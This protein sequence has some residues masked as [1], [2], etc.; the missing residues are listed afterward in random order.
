MS[1]RLYIDLQRVENYC[2]ADGR[3]EPIVS[4]EVSY[5]VHWYD[6]FESGVVGL[7]NGP[8][9][10]QADFVVAVSRLTTEQEFQKYLLKILLENGEFRAAFIDNRYNDKGLYLCDE[11]LSPEA[12]KALR[13]EDQP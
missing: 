13:L 2:F 5:Q 4:G 1:N 12:I 9:G 7:P 10:D 8:C 3:L 11:Y 6:D